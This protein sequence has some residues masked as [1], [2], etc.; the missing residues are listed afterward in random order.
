MEFKS[1]STMTENDA[2]ILGRKIKEGIAKKH[3]L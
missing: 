3:G 2:I 1:K